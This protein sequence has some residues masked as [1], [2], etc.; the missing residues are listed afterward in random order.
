M[1]SSTAVSNE[2]FKDCHGIG[3]DL[4]NIGLEYEK[5]KLIK[6]RSDGF[7]FEIK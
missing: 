1:Y 2:Y 5:V 4:A 3:A 6:F 7:I